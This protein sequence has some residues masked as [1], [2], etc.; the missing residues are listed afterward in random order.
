M[1]EGKNRV[2]LYLNSASV[3]NALTT[4]ILLGRVPRNEQRFYRS[5]LSSLLLCDFFFDKDPNI[6]VKTENFSFL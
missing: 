6:R 3:K 4:R 1:E 5:T 2:D